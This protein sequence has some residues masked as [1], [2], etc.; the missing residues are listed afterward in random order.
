[1]SVTP[2]YEKKLTSPEEAVALVKSGMFIDLGL[3]AAFANI[4]DKY[5]AK[6][7]DEL[8]NVTV[9]DC[10]PTCPLEILRVDPEQR[11]FK[12]TT[13]FVGNPTRSYIK[14]YGISIYRP[15]TLSDLPR[16]IR[17]VYKPKGRLDIAYLV[18]TPM[19]KDGYFNF[20]ASNCHHKA[21]ADAA[22]TVVVIEREDMPWVY[23]GYD[24]RIHIS[25]V[26]YIVEDKEFKTPEMLPAK[27]CE[28]DEMIAQNI[29]EAGIIENGSTVQVGIG[30]VPNAIITAMKDANYKDLGIHTEMYVDGMLELTQAGQITNKKKTLDNGKSVFMFAFGSRKLYDYIDRNPAVA[31][32]PVDYTND[33]ITIAQ[34]SKMFALNAALQVD[35]TS[36]VASEQLG[37]PDKPWH[38]S[39]T[40]GQLDFMR[41][42]LISRD[43]KGKSVI[44]L[45]STY[46]EF[47][48][49]VPLLPAGSAVTDP[50]TV[51]QYVATEWG[52]AYMRSY[53]IRE[54]AIGLINIAHPDH[55]DW[56]A[57]E[58]ERLGILPTK[59]TIP[60]GT[61]ENVV[62]KR[63]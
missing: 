44:S 28:T 26:D 2:E 17:E 1:M 21:L 52:V 36:Q 19:D 3:C 15:Y 55:R 9:E 63:D 46:K 30:P 50:R 10:I 34:Q 54:R 41:G 33:P 51:V 39:G 5:L 40:G 24:E 43:R 13:F 16:L 12:Y 38:V 7:K 29:I 37:L 23:G 14:D 31:T 35:L 25:E 32:Y 49:I 47:S 58:A 59:Y 60:A 27:P 18:T 11:V 8:E 42:T 20:G 56:L 62:V 48:N 53:S 6:R 61:P 45:Y 57:K 22:K 4:V